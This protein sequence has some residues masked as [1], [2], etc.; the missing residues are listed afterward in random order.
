[1]KSRNL[2]VAAVVAAFSAAASADDRFPERWAVEKRVELKD[3]AGLVVYSDGKMA[4]EDKYGNP[5]WKIKRGDS[6]ET[7]TGESILVNSNEG[8]RLDRSHPQRN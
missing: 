8:E 6:V 7:V 4:V 5:L 3:G 1:M 2:I